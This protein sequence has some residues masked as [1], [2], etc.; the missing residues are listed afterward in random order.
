M[1]KLKPTQKYWALIEVQPDLTL[2][3]TKANKYAVVNQHKKR[4]EST[5][6]RNVAR[7]INTGKLIIK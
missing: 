7:M 1:T 4:W 2:K 6:A 5:N 3:V